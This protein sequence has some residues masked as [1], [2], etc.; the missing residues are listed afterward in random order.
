MSRFYSCAC[1]HHAT[2]VCA[3]TVCRVSRGDPHSQTSSLLSGLHPFHRALRCDT[4]ISVLGVAVRGQSTCDLVSVT[5]PATDAVK[6]SLQNYLDAM[7]K[8]DLADLFR[9]AEGYG[10]IREASP[11]TFLSRVHF[12]RAISCHLSSKHCRMSDAHAG[13]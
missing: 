7:T 1:H 4:R 5:Q 12:W 11:C 2:T 6:F 3:G 10:V 13:P 8:R 9:A